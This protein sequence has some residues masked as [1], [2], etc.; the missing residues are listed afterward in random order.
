MPA[1]RAKPSSLLMNQEIVNT[2]KSCSGLELMHND[3]HQKENKLFLWC[4]G[5]MT[6]YAY[7]EKHG[8]STDCIV[9]R[10]KSDMLFFRGM[11]HTHTC[12]AH[13]ACM[14]T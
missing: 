3:I 8:L 4:Q 13:T 10:F 1:A 2:S 5:E 11:S 7:K 6:T 14:Y 12:I 9:A